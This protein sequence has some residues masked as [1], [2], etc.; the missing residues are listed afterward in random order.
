MNTDL[1][2]LLVIIGAAVLALAFKDKAKPQP[3]PASRWYFYGAKGITGSPE[4]YGTGFAFDFPDHATDHPRY[5]IGPPIQLT[6]GKPLTMRYTITGGGFVAQERPEQTASMSLYIQGQGDIN[7]LGTRWYSQKAQPLVAGSGEFAVLLVPDK[8][9]N[10]NGQHDP[11]AF[12][13][14]I[15]NPAYVGV[16]FGSENGRGHG[17]YA[18]QA[19]RIA[20]ELR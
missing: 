8:W 3:Q 9:I 12:A 14:A 7:G 20:A 11:V 4:P 10:V 16:V 15:G 1:I 19:S 18:T 2:P 6:A 5:V 17:V 13:R